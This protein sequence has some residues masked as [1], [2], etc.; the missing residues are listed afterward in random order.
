MNHRSLTCSPFQ[1]ADSKVR[2]I[3][4][5]RGAAPKEHFVQFYRTDEY[6]IECLAEYTADALWAGDV[7][8]VFATP[9]HHAALEE[10]LRVKGVDVVSSVLRHHYRAFDARETLNR[11]MHDGGLD[12]QKFLA[13]MSVVLD[14]ASSG[15]RPVRIFGEMVALLWADGNGTGALQLERAWNDVA[16]TYPFTL[17]CAYPAAVAEKTID[18]L[19]VEHI[20]QTHACV[21][22]AAIPISPTVAAR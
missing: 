20:C 2:T 15:Q 12:R 14:E 7:A 1:T 9:A 17:F 21:I 4:N 6:L 8:I 18:G 3:N 10:R 5:W 11:F 22:S 19:S 13:A 16:I